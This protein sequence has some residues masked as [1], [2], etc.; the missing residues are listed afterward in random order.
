MKRTSYPRF[1]ARAAMTLLAVLC[2][3]GARAEEVTIG[4]GTSAS[5]YAPISTYYNYS[6]TE[7]LYTADEIGMAGSISSISFYYAY[8]AVN[9]E[10]DITVYMQNVDAADLLTG[11]SLA[12]ADEV[13]SGTISITEQGW[14]TI[15]LD[16]P[17]AYDGTSNLLI[18]INKTAGSQW[19][20]GATWQYTTVT[21]MA[22]YTQND[23][24]AYDTSTVPANVTN[25]RPNIKI[26]ITP[27]GDV[28]ICA[29]PST[30]VVSDITTTGATFEWEDTGAESYSFEYKKASDTEWTPVSVEGVG[31]GD[32]SIKTY[33]LSDLDPGTDYNARVK[34]ICGTDSE[35]GYKTL[36]FTTSFSIPLVEE[37]GT[38]VPTGWAM[39]SGLL[40]IV[41][42][43][44]ELATS[45][46]GWS[47]GS[48][49]GVFDNH[50]RVNIYGTSCQY[51]LVTP[52]LL[53]ENNVQLMFNVAYTA[54]SGSGG[55]PAQTGSD[56]KFVVLI[57][58]GN[59]WTILRQW[60]NAG[61]EYVLNDLNATPATVTLDLSSYAGQSIAI[62][63]YGE[64]TE[65]NADNNLH[66]DNVSID[67]I[68]ACPKPTGLAV[69]YEGGTTATVTWEGTA[70]AY[71]IDVNGTVTNGVT[72]PYTLENLDLAATYEVKVQAACSESE[73]SE[74]TNAVSFKTDNCMPEDMCSLTFEMADSYGDGW[75]GA[76]IAIYDYT[77]EEVG[78]LLATVTLSSGA[79]GTQTL[80]FCNGQELAIIWSSASYD[81]ECSY[82]ITDINGDIVAQD[83][84]ELG[85]AYTID[86]TVTDCRRPTD[87][88]ASE[89]G[90]HSAV[91]S[92]TENGEATA[93]VIEYISENDEES[94]TITVESNPYTLTGL[95][96]ETMYAAQV[97]PVCDDNAVK[98]SEVISWTTTVAAPAPTNLVAKRVN[99]NSATLNWEG[100]DN[101]NSY[102][103]RYGKA[104][105]DVDPSTPATIILTAP[106][107]WTDGSGYQM[108]LDANATAYGTIIPESGG[109]TS[110][111]NA[112]EET[113]AEFEYKIPG[114]A[115]GALTTTNVVVNNSVSIQIPAGTYDWCIT[116]PTPGD[117]VWIAASNGNVGG[118]Q[119]DFVF[120]PG[121]TY[122]FTISMY[123]TNDGVDLTTTSPVEWITVEGVT[124]PYQLTDLDPSTE[125][126]WQVQANCGEEGLSQWSSTSTFTTGSYSDA[127]TELAATATS[128]TATLEWTGSQ[129]SYNVRYKATSDG[130]VLEEQDFED[131]I[132]GWT[133][134][135]ADGDGFTWSLHVNTG[136]GNY[137][138]HSGDASMNSGSYDG[139]SETALTPDNYLVSP[140]VELGGSISFWA[141]AQD[142]AWPNEHF[143]VAVSTTGNT[144]AADFTTIAEWTMTAAGT[145]AKESGTYGYYTVDLSAYSGQ[146]GYVAIRH[147]DCTDMFYLVIDDIVIQGPAQAETEWIT[148][149]NVS[150]N[151]VDIDGLDSETEY[152][153]QVQGILDNETTDWVSDNFTTLPLI[154]LANDDSENEAG[155]K[156]SAIIAAYAEQ[157][158]DVTL[159]GRTLFKDGSWNTLCL[160]FDVELEGSLL[161]GATAKTLA[162][163]TITGSH[164][165]LTFGDAVTT[166]EAGVPYIIKWTT[167]GEDISNPTFTGVTIQEV[168]EDDR[169]V[170]PID[171][172]KFIGYY[173][174]FGITA[175][176]Q[177]IYYMTADNTLKYTGKARTLKACRAYFEFSEAVT[178]GGVRE[179]TLNF[180]DNDATGIVSIDNEQLNNESG[181]YTVDGK[182]LDK[183]P[184]RKGVYINNG[185]KVVIK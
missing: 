149:E 20:S 114:N 115:D 13:F 108:L 43:G 87:F 24:T 10:Y 144:N 184:K 56:D 26:E 167:E 37:F 164:V 137:E 60:D 135:D 76:S 16:T 83:D 169:V 154:V 159:N 162:N 165:S 113:Y 18:G 5:Y 2:F 28:Q 174:A 14:V 74:W 63:F 73:T 138:T 55:A 30:F 170:S 12:D 40:D 69:S 50:A 75:N 101:A 181:W 8:T 142:A 104:S 67:Y 71:N 166:L 15:D 133:T 29:K 119:D 36:S 82:T 173:D 132:G 134:I 143:G 163:A 177:N 146:Q 84:T 157:T 64:S 128:T 98:P 107:L 185:I 80:N 54:Y 99:A 78:E 156:N 9:K 179:F 152:V 89:I 35:S 183:Q 45:N 7:Q 86:C 95:A 96:A 180:G 92:W 51:W 81:S 19:F 38:S 4:D 46:Y 127:P 150:G 125:Y 147:F 57:N 102:N 88:A 117:R 93:W 105:D 109:L 136:T 116:N 100:P 79:E 53:M 121:V 27:G 171:G 151:S 130:A 122:E 42:A 59:G 161:E 120:D 123:G 160:P 106:S 77:G 139:E 145:A 182:K 65:G 153:W 85:M 94:T 148:L 47:F 23:N 155:S 52:T 178:A 111:G 97:S 103:V 91:L 72:S 31:R 172:V 41:M 110:E 158:V 21:N 129:N 131:G 25:N 3:L 118:R 32:A 62:A 90:P 33:T 1:L 168:A 176:D 68:P 49:N 70:D 17:F 61:S 44:A 22:R 112:S 6:I 48:N 39:Y 11:I 124:S 175:A 126:Y 34:A 141:C 140:Q 58:N 66:I